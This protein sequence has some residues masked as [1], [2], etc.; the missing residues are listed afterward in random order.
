M[1]WMVLGFVPCLILTVFTPLAGQDDRLPYEAHYNDNL[2]YV[3][4]P[5]T[6]SG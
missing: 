4:F 3:G 5:P 1:R 2:L 6:P